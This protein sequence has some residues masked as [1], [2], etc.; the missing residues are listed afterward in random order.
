[1]HEQLAELRDRAEQVVAPDTWSYLNRGSG[2]ERTVQE[3]HDAWGRYRLRPRVLRDVSTVTTELDLFGPWRTPIG[4]APTAFHAL[5]HPDGE[6][7]TAAGA[8]ASGAPMVVSSRATRRLE[9]IAAAIDGPWWFQVYL[10]RERSIT[11]SLIER[12]AA[13]GATAMVLT[14]DTPYVGHRARSAALS[15][16]LPLT[17]EQAL[18]NMRDHLPADVADIWE[19]IDQ[20]ADLSLTDIGWVADVSHLPVIVKGVLRADDAVACAEAG[21]SGIWVSNHGGRQLD[22]VVPTAVALPEIV[23][24]VGDSVPVIVDGGVRDGFDALTALALG[25][26]AV[27]LGRPAMW[28]LAAGGSDAVTAMLAE[29]SAELAHALGL[30]GAARLG[31]LDPTMVTTR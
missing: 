20:R 13:A 2:D 4:I 14:A 7:A 1:M 18:T 9:D 12:A 30:A 6:V 5:L 3:A 17:D 15:R 16:P 29:L 21:A 31:D 28:A 23:A 27:M 26:R 19:L 24:A 25:A 10:M 11:A 8:A 22:R